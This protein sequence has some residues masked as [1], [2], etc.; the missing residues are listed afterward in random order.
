[1]EKKIWYLNDLN[2]PYLY[3]TRKKNDH[4][5]PHPKCPYFL[6]LVPLLHAE[7]ASFIEVTNRQGILHG[8]IVLINVGTSSKV[9]GHRLSRCKNALKIGRFL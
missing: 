2:V 8:E 6:Q 1:M 9:L 4:T 7:F 5:L 3:H